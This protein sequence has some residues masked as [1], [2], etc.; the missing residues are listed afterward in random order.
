MS[1]H[2]SGP[3]DVQNKGTL[4]TPS[5]RVEVVEGVFQ[6]DEDDL[7]TVVIMPDLSEQSYARARLI[8][9]APDLLEAC[10]LAR[11]HINVTVP[12]GQES[13]DAVYAAITKAK[14]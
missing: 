5:A 1:K 9:A 3:W 11:R 8:A 2:T 10:E 7:P 4:G 14:P 6:G 13:L 12:G